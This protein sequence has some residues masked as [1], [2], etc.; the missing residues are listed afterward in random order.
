[1]HVRS[2]DGD[3]SERGCLKAAHIGGYMRDVLDAGVRLRVRAF[4]IDVV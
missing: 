2:G 4:A 1:M 3:V